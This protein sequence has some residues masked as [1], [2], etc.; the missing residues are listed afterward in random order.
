MF[1]SKFWKTIYTIGLKFLKAWS[2][3]LVIKYGIAKE[4]V[5]NRKILKASLTVVL[6][7]LVLFFNKIEQQK[8]IGNLRVVSQ[9]NITVCRSCRSFFF[10]RPEVNVE[11]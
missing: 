8:I 6:L 1:N 5:K 2:Y 3:L 10:S 11:I 9:T 7:F 4:I